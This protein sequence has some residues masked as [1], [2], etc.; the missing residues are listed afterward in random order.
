METDMKK[1]SIAMIVLG[2]GLFV[3][4]LSGFSANSRFGYGWYKPERIEMALGV[5][6]ALLG[7]FSN[8]VSKKE[9]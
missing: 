9:K 8:K 5:V 6:L 1:T 2:G 4:G 7:W 3:L